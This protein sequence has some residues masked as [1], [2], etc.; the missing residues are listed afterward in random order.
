MAQH[1]SV[2]LINAHSPY[3]KM[4]SEQFE[5]CHRTLLQYVEFLCSAFTPAAA[6]AQLIPSLDD[7]V[8]LY[9]LDPE[10]TMKQIRL[11]QAQ[12]L[13]LGPPRWAELLDTVKTMLP[14][15]A[16]ND[17]SPD[18][19]PNSQ[20]DTYGQFIKLCR[21]SLKRCSGLQWHPDVATQLVVESTVL[22]ADP[23][24][25]KSDG[26]HESV[27]PSFDDV[28]QRALVV[29]DYKGAVARCIAANKIADAL[30][31]AH[32][33]GASLCDNTRDQYLKNEPFTLPEGEL[34]SFVCMEL[35]YLFI[36]P[37]ENR[38]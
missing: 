22:S 10:M 6:Y 20:R 17:L 31:I 9:H 32:V 5:R 21:F 30:V 14:S 3:I 18:L 25:Q 2:V 35:K 38:N 28:V 7:L 15:K 23:I 27:D 24:P 1:R 37:F 16:W 36:Y 12:S 33:D 34:N 8:H 11:Q 29:G 26:L 19:Y 13:D 4:V